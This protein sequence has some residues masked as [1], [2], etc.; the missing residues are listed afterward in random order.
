[1]FVQSCYIKKNNPE[2]KA[3]LEQFGYH[4]DNNIP[5]TNADC[6]VTSAF[7]DSYSLQTLSYIRQ[8]NMYLA[9]GTDM[10]DCKMNEELFLAIAALRTASDHDDY[11]QW[12]T[13]G[14]AVNQDHWYQ[15]KEKNSLKDKLYQKAQYGCSSVFNLFHKA[16]VQELIM[17]FGNS[18][19]L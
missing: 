17:H 9:H 16:S 8:R 18:H 1:M 15:Y 13:D 6:L 5:N 14:M 11:M 12:F 7:N 10:I 2:L 4:Q 3:K 19:Y